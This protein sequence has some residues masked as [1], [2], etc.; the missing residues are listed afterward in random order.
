M[1]W[2]NWR[3]RGISPSLSKSGICNRFTSSGPCTGSG[4]GL[5][6]D[7]SWTG[8]PP[9][10]PARKPSRRSQTRAS[11]KAQNRRRLPSLLIVVSLL[12]LRHHR[13]VVVITVRKGFRVEPKGPVRSRVHDERRLLNFSEGEHVSSLFLDFL[14][15]LFEKLAK[16]S[17]SAGDNDVVMKSSYAK[18]NILLFGVRCSI[19]S[20]E[21]EDIQAGL[22][23]KVRWRRWELPT[24]IC[25]KHA[26]A[27][28]VLI[29]LTAFLVVV[30]ID[31]VSL[32]VFLHAVLTVGAADSG[33]PPPG[34]ESL[35]GLEVF[36]VHIGF[37][38]LISLQA[39][40][41]HR[42]SGYRWKRLARIR[43]RS[44]FRWPHQGL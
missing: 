32:Q 38:K 9:D 41:R 5:P 33:F 34:V 15:S 26:T 42:G 28:V 18:P 27:E 4:A 12:K 30:D 2:R 3:T 11:D 35:H 24:S 21:V 16:S 17:R 25:A 14:Q 43:S 10:I 44:P 20:F 8:N 31:Y 23:G 13:R 36:P 22:A 29:R 1:W 6:Q 19:V 40:S 39:P 37:T 7:P